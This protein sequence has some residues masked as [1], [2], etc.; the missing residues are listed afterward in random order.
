MPIYEYHCHGCGN[1][2]EVLLPSPEST[3]LCPVCGQHLFK[4]LISAP[5]VLQ[6]SGSAE[7]RESTC[8]GRDE[9]CDAPPCAESGTC[10]R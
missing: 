6:R 7:E 2:V 4:K 8:C 1:R 3:A 10:R 5:F 9:R